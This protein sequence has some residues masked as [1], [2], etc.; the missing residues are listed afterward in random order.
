MT[1]PRYPSPTTNFR[2]SHST[3]Q[4]YLLCGVRHEFE[5]A[6]R[7]RRVPQTLLVSDPNQPL[8]PPGRWKAGHFSKRVRTPK[9]GPA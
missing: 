2:I 8:N 3:L 6:E 1:E 5:Q 4:T 7:H 9:V